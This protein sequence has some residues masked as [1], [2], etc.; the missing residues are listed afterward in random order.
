MGKTHPRLLAPFARPHY[1]ARPS[2]RSGNSWTGV[3]SQRLAKVLMEQH[4]GLEP[5]RRQTFASERGGLPTTHPIVHRRALWPATESPTFRAGGPCRTRTDRVSRLMDFNSLTPGE[6]ISPARQCRVLLR[7]PPHAHQLCLRMKLARRLLVERTPAA[8]VALRC[9]FA[10]RS[11]FSCLAT[12]GARALSAPSRTDRLTA[13]PDAAGW[14]QPR[15]SG[16]RPRSES[17]RGPP[18]AKA[19]LRHAAG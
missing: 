14:L 6:N 4:T 9:G 17:R 18:S 8:H 5:R 13:A 3:A 19:W 16:T 12:A 2:W 1:R 15:S 11:H 7:L 10:D